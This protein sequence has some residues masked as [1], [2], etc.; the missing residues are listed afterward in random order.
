M[1]TTAEAFRAIGTSAKECSHNAKQFLA[2]WD[3]LSLDAHCFSLYGV[4]ASEFTKRTFE[5]LNAKKPA[6]T[7]REANQ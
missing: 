6:N 5:A 2:S 7:K 1:T 4:S 3:A